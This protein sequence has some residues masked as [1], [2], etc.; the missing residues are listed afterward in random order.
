[1]RRAFILANGTKVMLDR[2]EFVA[3]AGTAQ[4][5]VTNRITVGV[6]IPTYNHTHFL[7][8]A[9]SSVLAQTRPAD[10]IIVVD[11]GSTDD[12]MSVVAQFPTINSSDRITV[13]SRRHATRA[14]AFAARA[15][16]CS[17]T[18]TIVSYLPQL[19]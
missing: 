17:L 18:Q 2:R 7:A 14:F 13:V 4:V 6:V 1:M 11:D 5:C 16:S 19:K 8:E 10:E 15:T 3:V 9:I 12:P